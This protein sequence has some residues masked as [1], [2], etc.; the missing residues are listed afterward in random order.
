VD[1]SREAR[2]VAGLS[3]LAVPTVMYGGVTLLGVLTHGA[4]GLSPGKLQ[5]TDTQW[6]LFRA[7]HAHAGVWLAL[8]LVIQLLLDGAVLSAATKWL[9]RIAAPL[10]AVAISAGF[11]G[12]AYG[13]R[14]TPLLWFGALCLLIAVVVTGVGLLRRTPSRV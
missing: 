2:I 14:F 7:G 10:A 3:L 9:A 5:L 8:S 6:A 4:A 11:F 1:I 12:L 13:V